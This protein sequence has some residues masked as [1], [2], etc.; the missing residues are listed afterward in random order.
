MLGLAALLLFFIFT[1]AALAN[2]TSLDLANQVQWLQ[3]PSGD[4]TI[5]RVSRM[6]DQHFSSGREQSPPHGFIG[7]TIWLKFRIPPALRDEPR[8]ILLHALAQTDRITLFQPLADGGYSSLTLGDGVPFN[9]RE[10]RFRYPAFNIEPTSGNY[11][12]RIQS[13]GSLQTP[14]SL[15]TPKAFMED[16]STRNLLVGLY[17]GMMLILVLAGFMT[18]A[19]VREPVFLAYSGYLLFHQQLQFTV[20]GLS[21]QFFW[22]DSPSWANLA[23]AV[24]IGLTLVFASLFLI[25]LLRTRERTPNIHRILLALILIGL[26]A[27]PLAMLVGYRFSG[28]LMSVSGIA[29]AITALAASV[30]TLKQGYK[31]ARFLLL[32]WSAFMV[33][34]VVTALV[35]MGFMP[36]TGLGRHAMQIGST[37]EVLLLFMAL[38]DRIRQARFEKSVIETGIR[39]QLR[40][41]NRQLEQEVKRRTRELREKNIEL[42]ELA[43]QDG[44][45][46]LLNHKFLFSGVDA[47]LADALRYQYPIAVLMI[48]LDHFKQINDRLGHSVGDRVLIDLADTLRSSCR[49]SDM[50]GRYGGD[51]FVMVLSHAGEDEAVPFAERL[52]LNINRIP[53]GGD[54]GWTLSAS[55]GIAVLVPGTDIQSAELM[56]SADRA[57]YAAKEAGRNRIICVEAAPPEPQPET[58]ENRKVTRLV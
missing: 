35:Y 37:L 48:D 14:L 40:R 41:T 1:N 54:H 19:M 53:V 7:R 42:A 46:G 18:F 55:I 2:Q 20:N 32:G 47:I 33:G 3:D 43:T 27:L 52:K 17:H 39:D 24:T 21:F 4:L 13:S 49:Q 9:E 56:E 15:M 11:F 38:T 8:L 36:S 57:L 6:G 29:L 28:A 22:P 30:I 45:T 34:L 58:P 25:T 12:A 31:P 16:A 10:I 23:P 5:D 44:L 26:L 50:V 51:E